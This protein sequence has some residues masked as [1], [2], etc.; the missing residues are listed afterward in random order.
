MTLASMLRA[1]VCERCHGD[2]AMSLK[3]PVVPLLVTTMRMLA[4][5]LMP[6]TIATV[7]A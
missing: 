7:F 5:M 6:A 1:M 4:S 2:D 3:S